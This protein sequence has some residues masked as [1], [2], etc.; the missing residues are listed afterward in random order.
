MQ[1]VQGAVRTPLLLSKQWKV[2]MAGDTE[3]QPSWARRS[4]SG[5]WPRWTRSA[6]PCWPACSPN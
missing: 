1:L 3:G 6:T 2:A 4:C 5:W